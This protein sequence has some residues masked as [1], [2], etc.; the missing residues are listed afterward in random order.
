LTLKVVGE[1][2][3]VESMVSLAETGVVQSSASRPPVSPESGL[4]H[5]KNW[6]VMSLVLRYDASASIQV[7][8]L[9]L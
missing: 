1:D 5:Q 6:S 7:A 8:S 2:T 3:R 9:P 4:R